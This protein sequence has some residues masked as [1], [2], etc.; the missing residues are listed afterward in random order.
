MHAKEN[1]H[2]SKE[3]SDG[4]LLRKRK[5]I[6]LPYIGRTIGSVSSSPDGMTTSFSLLLTLSQLLEA[7][8]CQGNVF[9]NSSTAV[10]SCVSSPFTMVSGELATL[11]SGSNWLFSR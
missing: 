6:V 5:P 1:N 7:F 11:M 4:S 2:H 8:R 3:G 9:S 10:L